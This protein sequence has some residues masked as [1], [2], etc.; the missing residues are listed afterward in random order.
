MEKGCSFSRDVN[1]NCIAWDMTNPV[2]KQFVDQDVV[3]DNFVFFSHIGTAV[4][5]LHCAAPCETVV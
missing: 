2:A 5:P 4:V 1:E 3:F